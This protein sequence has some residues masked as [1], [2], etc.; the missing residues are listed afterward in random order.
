MNPGK[1]MPMLA[2]YA[3]QMM[4]ARFTLTTPLT[5]YSNVELLLITI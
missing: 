3:A 1:L 2:G 4:T 5:K